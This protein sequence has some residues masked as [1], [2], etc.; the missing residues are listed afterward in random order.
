MSEKK[1]EHPAVK[2]AGV[3]GT[4]IFITV[5]VLAVVAREHRSN[6]GWRDEFRDTRW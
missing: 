5:L 4:F 6:V 3:V 1:P 2:I